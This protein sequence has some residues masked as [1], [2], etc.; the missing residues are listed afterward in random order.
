MRM[1]FWFSLAL[2]FCQEAKS[3]AAAPP[4]S[5][6]DIGS[7]KEL[8]VDGFLI[9]SL[10][11]ARL[12]LHPPVAREIV[13]TFDKPWEGVYS[14][15]LTVL[16]DQNK[17]RMYYRGL[18]VAKHSLDAEVTCLVESKDGIEWTRPTV[19]IYEVS[20]AR[21]NNV[22]LARHRA[23][24]NLAPFI[25]TRPGAPAEQRYKALGGT[26][27]PGLI[28]FA[29][30]D[31]I[32]WK[33]L[34]ENP[35]IT[36][37]AFDSQNIA[38]WSEAESRYVCYFRVFREGVRWI[39]RSD[40][41]DFVNWSQPVDLDPGKLPRQHLYTN[42][43]LPCPGAPHLYI[44]FPTRFF[45]NR[46]ALSD[47]ELSH[48]GTPKEWGYAKDCTD[49]VLVSTRGGSQFDR[50]FMEAWI[51][52]GLDPKNW[53]SRA[54]YGAHGLVPTAANELSLY[55]LHNGGYPTSHVR[56]YSLRPEGF[57]SLQGP[58]QGGSATTVA[59]KFQGKRLKLNCSTSAAGGIRVEVQTPEGK[60][61]P[62][63]SLADCQEIL[64]DSLEKTV[65]WKKS[66]VEAL[67]GMAVRLKFE[68]RDAD[69][70]SI[71]FVK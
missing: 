8:F 4:A 50:S 68:L 42:Q 28:A 35:V 38:F 66:S 64:G 62:G 40:S 67:Q 43:M 46:R 13:H 49:I 21:E 17:F 7:R 52:P 60:A 20:G 55:V 19:G 27:K 53:T 41:L 37:G 16:K 23:C 54:S 32:H 3:M 36:E 15:Y 39:A 25:D 5:P 58:Y 11:G 10:N 57:A 63:Y 69:L 22:V 24:H 59:L 6:V 71:Q 45:P 70:Y 2:L 30:P 29:S 31:G 1:P 48:L 33:P 18:P 34:Q 9:D 44:G 61:I 47:E 12:A 26:G 56:R 14:G 51:R 65:Q